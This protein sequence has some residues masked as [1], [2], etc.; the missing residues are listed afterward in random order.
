[1]IVDAAQSAD[2]VEQAI[3]DTVSHRLRLPAP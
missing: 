1:V 3:W 2:E